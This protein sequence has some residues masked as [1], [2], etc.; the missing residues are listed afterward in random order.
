MSSGSNL[1]YPVLCGAALAACL[2][3]NPAYDPAGAALDTGSSTAGASTDIPAPGGS[4][5]EPTTGPASTGDLPPDTTGAPDPASTGMSS[6]PGDPTGAPAGCW[7]LPLDAFA[8]TPLPP[9]AIG[10][11]SPSLSPDGLHLFFKAPLPAPQ[12]FEVRRLTRATTEDD[13]PAVAETFFGPPDTDGLDYPEVFAGGE[14]IFFTQKSGDIF[15]ARREGGAWKPWVIAGSLAVFDQARFESHPNTTEDGALLLFQRDDGPPV[16]PLR[17]TYR[18]YQTTDVPQQNG[19]AAPPIDVTPAHPDLVI[20]VCPAMSPDGLHLLFAAKDVQ[21]ELEDL[22]DGS[23]GVWSTHR[24][25]LD[26]PWEQPVRSDTLR[27]KGAVTCPTSITADGC[28]AT[29]IHFS[30]VNELYTM[31]LA[32]R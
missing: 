29:I 20:P 23:V 3:P 7:D 22:D 4:S 12:L 32:R 25:A 18:F 17:A 30:T 13:F 11:S 24:P 1:F 26:A 27:E 16:G 31:H 14:R 9:Q 19:F 10:A 28:Q 5:G 21:G 6:E 15:T 8:L 2:Q